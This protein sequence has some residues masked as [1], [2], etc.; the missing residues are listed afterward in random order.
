MAMG[1]RTCTSRRRPSSSRWCCWANGWKARQAPDH[2]SDPRAAGLR[3]ATARVQRDGREVDLPL[4]QWRRATGRRAARR[5]HA[6]RRRGA[7]RP[8][9]R[10]RIPASPARACRRARTRRR[11]TGGA[12]NGEGL[13]VIRATALGAESTLARIVRLVESA[14]AAKAPIQRLV[15]QVS[16]VFVPVV[17]GIALL[18]LLGWGWRRRLGGRHPERGGGAGDRLP[19]CAGTGHARGHHGRHRRGGAARHPDQ[20]CRSAGTRA[21]GRR[22]R[23]RQD[24]HAHRRQAA[25]GRRAGSADGDRGGLLRW[26]PRCRPAANTR[27]RAPCS[28]RH[29]TAPS[30][31]LRPRASMRSPAAA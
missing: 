27:S 17:V 23:L 3:P 6:G 5:A 15:D 18:T 26:P 7:R 14:Q 9:P 24:R 25:A 8:Q 22:G 30:T 29:V 21:P 31:R 20:G 28:S 4:A 2:G 13:L 11:V 10:R 16:A 1:T 19:L 12:V